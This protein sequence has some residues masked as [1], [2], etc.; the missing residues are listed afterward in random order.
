MWDYGDGTFINTT[1]WRFTSHVY[2]HFGIYNVSVIIANDISMQQVWQLIQ[3]ED[4]LLNLMVINSAGIPKPAVPFP[5]YFNMLAGTN[6]TCQW[7][8]GGGGPT[9]TSDDISSPK[10]NSTFFLTFLNGGIFTITVNCSNHISAVN[11]SLIQICQYPIVNLHLLNKGY[12]LY[13]PVNVSFAIDQGSEVTFEFYFDGV[14]CPT[15]FWTNTKTGSTSP[16]LAAYPVGIHEV[17]IRAYNFISDVTLNSTFIIEY[18][19]TNAF[20]SLDRSI[21]VPGW[22]ITFLAGMQFGTSAK[23]TWQYGDSANDTYA[24]PLLYMWPTG[25]LVTQSH[26]FATS[27]VYFVQTTV[28]N[29]YNSFTFE[30]KV[31]TCGLLTGVEFQSNAPVYY[32]YTIGAAT[33]KFWFIVIL[34]LPTALNVTFDYG[35][36]SPQE[37]FP[38]ELNYNYTHDYKKM[39]TMKV[40]ATLT[41]L[42]TTEYYTTTITTVEPITGFDVRRSPPAAPIDLLITVS[43]YLISGQNITFG[44]D[45][46]DG[47]IDYWKRI[48]V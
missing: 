13:K 34:N 36:G 18:P 23:I 37:T 7:N 40:V 48:G 29:A 32:N 31:Y 4:E 33:V 12:P 45:W 47:T 9:L 26:T 10:D 16:L 39:T 20:V 35:D 17:S 11:T 25:D 41:D 19:I 27:G 15:E 44:I 43:F 2:R 3:I 24:A 21:I 22:S 1:D 8:L 6:Y 38:F 28:E 46:G 30:Q 5:Y 42:V 14:Q